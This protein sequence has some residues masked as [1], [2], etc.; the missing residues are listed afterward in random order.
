V[1]STALNIA[2][3]GAG[4]MGL[5]AAME[6]ANRG[7]AVHVFERDDRIGGMSAHFEFD[8]I[9]VERY[10]HFICKPD[11]P[12]FDLLAELGLD[13]LLRWVDTRMGFYC[14]GKLYDWGTPK[15][16]LSFDQI[17]LLTKLR[18]GLM[19]L[20]AKRIRNWR[21]YDR[22]SAV[23]WLKRWLGK[24][25]YDVLWRRLFELKFYERS[26]ELSAAWLGT[27]IKRV[28][29][30]RRSLVQETL[31]YLEGGSKVLLD[32][33]ERRIRD[34]GGCIHL[35]TGVERVL[36]Q[37]RGVVTGVLV[38]D[39]ELAFDKV[40]STVPIQYVPRLA[41]DLPGPFRVQIEAIDNIAV[42]CVVLKLDRTLTGNFWLNISDP[43]IGIPGLIEYTNL[44]PLGGTHIVYAPYYMPKSHAKFARSNDEFIHETIGYLG[45]VNRNFDIDWLRATHCHRYEFAQTICPP[46]F[47]S[48]LPPMRTPLSGLFMAD[49]SY[50]YPEDRSISESLRIGKELAEC[51]LA[52]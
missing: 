7:H 11:Q 2:V 10:Y 30:S 49:T 23:A 19:A 45:A 18:Y 20:H 43:E 21:P 51:A 27:R 37:G 22:F 15:A 3:I 40:I 17:G 35:R 8:G 26:E 31:G 29:L 32:A 14:N 52:D 24:R 48:R 38:N 50:Y 4:P 34:R 41:P 33:M 1:T 16:L 36:T 47:Y 39:Q 12:L 25:G 13:D 42:V 6:F 9:D 46:G 28:A 5:M 44:N